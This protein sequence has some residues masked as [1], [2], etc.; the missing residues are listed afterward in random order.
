MKDNNSKDKTTPLPLEEEI[1]TNFGAVFLQYAN[2]IAAGIFID[3]FAGLVVSVLWNKFIFPL[4]SP[5]INIFHGIGLS[6][7]VKFIQN[8]LDLNVEACRNSKTLLLS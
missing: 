2:I 1:Q 4:G 3:V 7:L 6:M 8:P 5:K